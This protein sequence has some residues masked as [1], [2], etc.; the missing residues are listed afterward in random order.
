MEGVATNIATAAVLFLL[1]Q[2]AGFITEPTEL[3]TTVAV[4]AA[5]SAI[6]LFVVNV[7][8]HRRIAPYAVADPGSWEAARVQH[9]PE[10][11]Q[12]KALAEWRSRQQAYARYVLRQRSFRNLL[13]VTGL[14]LALL[15]GGVLAAN[16]GGL[17]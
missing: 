3:L 13:R 10:E 6:A 15:F 16:A 1:A 7:D 8:F 12:V 14:L 5:F 17:I 4:L 2:A 11:E 9:L